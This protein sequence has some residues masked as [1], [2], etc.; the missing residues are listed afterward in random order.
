MSSTNTT[1]E[2]LLRI[3]GRAPHAPT[4]DVSYHT[5]VV[6]G[7]QKAPMNPSAHEQLRRDLKKV[8]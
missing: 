1:C 5:G 3:V 7:L 2:L 4:H 8:N 6:E